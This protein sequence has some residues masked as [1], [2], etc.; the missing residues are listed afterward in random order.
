[1]DGGS[2]WIQLLTKRPH[3]G[4]SAPPA[5][6]VGSEQTTISKGQRLETQK[7]NKAALGN[8]LPAPSRSLRV[9]TNLNLKR[10]GAPG[11]GCQ[12]SSLCQKQEPMTSLITLLALFLM[13]V[14]ESS[15]QPTP[16]GRI[17][18]ELPPLPPLISLGLGM[19]GERDA[20]PIV[21]AC[22]C[23]SPFAQALFMGGDRIVSVN[24]TKV[25]TVDDVRA[26][27]A[28]ARP[29]RSIEFEL[30][31]QWGGQISETVV[32][33]FPPNWWLAKPKKK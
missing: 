28:L 4:L 30:I 33:E 10:R 22:A 16:N 24:G 13:G 23:H 14:A 11:S 7:A 25:R 19:R 8:P 31:K 3:H 12:A 9:A 5:R 20:A 15:L 1:M 32:V 17:A 27:L 26:A 2:Q 29:S 6:T 18:S 21:G